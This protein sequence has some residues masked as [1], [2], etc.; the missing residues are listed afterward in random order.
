MA[1]GTGKDHFTDGDGPGNGPGDEGN[2][3]A[4][5]METVAV[6]VVEGIKHC[7]LRY[8][9]A[10]GHYPRAGRAKLLFSI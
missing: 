2:S 8:L 9:R 6:D 7:I 3:S 5:D 10:Y 4:Q 1:N